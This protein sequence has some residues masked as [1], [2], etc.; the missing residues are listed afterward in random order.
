MIVPVNIL[1]KE[2]GVINLEKNAYITR[3]KRKEH[4]FRKYKGYGISVSILQYIKTKGVSNII[5]IEENKK[6]ERIYRTTRREFFKKGIRHTD[7][8]ADRQLILPI[9]EWR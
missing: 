7:K 3:R 9:T 8:Q 1:G 6:G 5:L 4:Y 2:M